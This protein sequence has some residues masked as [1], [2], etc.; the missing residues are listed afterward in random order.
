ML[1]KTIFNGISYRIGLYSHLCYKYKALETKF[2]P[3][4]WWQCGVG[5]DIGFEYAVTLCILGVFKRAMGEIR[6]Y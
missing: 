1:F 4:T 6:F 3:V 2:N 5:Y